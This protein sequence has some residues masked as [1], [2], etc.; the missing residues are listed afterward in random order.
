[1]PTPFFPTQ[2]TSATLN[3]GDN[4]VIASST[5]QAI[6]VWKVIVSPGA[7]ADSVTL[8]FTNGGN[9]ETAIISVAANG[10]AV[11]C[12][13]DGVPYALCDPGTAFVVNSGTTTTKLTAY[14]T[15]GA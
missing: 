9:A 10:G 2:I 8:K 4:T 1:M 14:Y 7:N 11:V 3:S 6:K 15:K 5:G 12:P 13:S